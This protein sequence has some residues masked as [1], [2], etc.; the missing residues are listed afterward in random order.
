[1]KAYFTEKS[2]AYFLERKK[3]D[4]RVFEYLESAVNQSIEK[5]KVPT[6]YLLALTYYYAGCQKLT[7]EQSRLCRL[8]GGLLIAEGLV[9]PYTRELS[10]H[11][12]VPEDIMD[13]AMVEY[14]GRRDGRPELL[15][16][17]LPDEEQFHSE[18]IRRVYQGIFVKQKILFEGESMEYRIYDYEEG[19]RVL[20]AEGRVA[21]DHKL[22]GKENSRFALL[23]QMGAAQGKKDEEALKKAM[24]DYLKKAAV[25]SELFPI[26]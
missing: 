16:R 5:D 19:K 13:K 12:A 10:R 3:V 23:N 20:A 17:I 7:E 21:C 24:E 14:I 1:M 2:V 11:M 22:D 6:I 9:F 26:I 18:E 8:I 4:G 25:L 15:V